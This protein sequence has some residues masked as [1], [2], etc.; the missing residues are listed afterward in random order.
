MSPPATTAQPP[1]CSD[2]APLAA[3]QPHRRVQ[4][5][6]GTAVGRD[7]IL[8]GCLSFLA[9]WALGQPQRPQPRAARTT[10]AAATG[11]GLGAQAHTRWAVQ[12][13]LLRRAALGT[14]PVARAMALARD[15]SLQI[16]AE[17]IATTASSVAT[18]WKG[19]LA[20]SSRNSI[21][22]R[23]SLVALSAA[24]KRTPGLLQLSLAAIQPGGQKQVGE[25]YMAA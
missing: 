3:A 18:A 13:G 20:S 1:A 25:A 14:F 11:V 10:A 5:T 9:H 19:A 6:P 2:S 16:T 24:V 15:L 8:S 17:I 22:W 4:Y 7:T 12:T 23:P 21:T